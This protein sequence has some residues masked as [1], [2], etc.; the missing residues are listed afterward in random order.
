MF[1]SLLLPLLSSA[2]LVAAGVQDVWWNITYVQDI[3]PDGMF[4]RRV[5]GVNGKWP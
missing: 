2:S 1:L 4:S 5:I 3:N